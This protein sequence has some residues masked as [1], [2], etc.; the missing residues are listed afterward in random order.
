MSRLFT[1][2]KTNF[3]WVVWLFAIGFVIYLIAHVALSDDV[4]DATLV[5]VGDERIDS[6]LSVSVT[7]ADDTLLHYAR[8]DV[9]FNPRRHIANCAAYALRRDMITGVSIRTEDFARDNAVVGCASLQD[10]A[11][12]GY[13]RGHLVPAADMSAEEVSMRE[14]F[15][16]T[17]ICPQRSALNTGA[18]GDLEEKVREWAARDSLLLVVTGGIVSDT[19]QTI[20]SGVVVPDAFF[21]MV[22]A[23]CVQP[24]RVIPFVLP[25]APCV[26]RLR[27]YVVPLAE[28]ER[29]AGITFDG[30]RTLRETW[31]DA[32]LY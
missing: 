9:H 25:T 30:A 21:K 28:V 5:P 29:R 3:K 26:G 22:M 2:L 15:L 4:G 31:L 32:W 17:N 16:L 6:L 19:S 12:S 8:F 1:T 20:G 13:D 11:G 14:S 7:T 10:Y 23:P 27:D 24:A 18:W